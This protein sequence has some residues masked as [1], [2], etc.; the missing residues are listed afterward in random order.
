[1]KL[2]TIFHS[3]FFNEIEKESERGR[4]KAL[5]WTV[6]L[7]LQLTRFNW[8]KNKNWTTWK[9]QLQSVNAEHKR[10]YRKIG[11]QLGKYLNGIVLNE[12]L[13]NGPHISFCTILYPSRR[14]KKQIDLQK[15]EW[16]LS[17]GERMFC[18]CNV[19]SPKLNPL[20]VFVDCR[21]CWTSF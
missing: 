4:K 9:I 19:L 7:L 1:M 21:V 11:K 13:S 18:V 5:A 6:F 2:S 20:P 8:E 12:Q 10:M 14:K 15:C 17:D 3:D 16:Q